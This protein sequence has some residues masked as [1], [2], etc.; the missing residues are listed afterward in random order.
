MNVLFSA[1]VAN[2]T[3]SPTH[4]PKLEDKGY[5]RLPGFGYYKLHRERH[6]WGEAVEVCRGEGTHLL[7][8][9]SNDEARKVG[10]LTR[11]SSVPGHD[12]WTGVHDMFKEGYYITIFSKYHDILLL[13]CICCH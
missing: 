2:Q 9:N 6:L 7:I 13:A 5:Q 8:L 10:Q 3:H 12:C 4:N 1:A 11:L